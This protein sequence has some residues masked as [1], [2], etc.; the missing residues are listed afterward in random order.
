MKERKKEAEKN[1]LTPE[2]GV[3]QNPVRPVSANCAP[4]CLLCIC[5]EESVLQ[6]FA[7]GP[8]VL[9]M[10]HLRENPGDT[11]TSSVPSWVVIMGFPEATAGD[12]RGKSMVGGG[13][14]A[15]PHSSLIPE[16]WSWDC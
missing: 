13:R 1:P 14:G 7:L 16:E 3:S 11:H 10:S 15:P 8:S 6:G 12:W 4:W 9:L 5:P 2:N